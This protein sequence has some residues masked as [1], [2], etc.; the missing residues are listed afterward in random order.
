MSRSGALHRDDHAGRAVE[1]RRDVD[2]VFGPVLQADEDLR[3]LVDGEGGV[4]RPREAEHPFRVGDDVEFV[5]RLSV[6]HL[7]E[8]AV[9]GIEWP[10]KLPDI[11]PSNAA[12][13]MVHDQAEL[14]ALTG[15]TV[16]TGTGDNM[17]A[18]LGLAVK[19]GDTVISLGTSGTIYG[20]TETGVRDATGAINGYADAT[21]AFLP[22]GDSEMKAIGGADKFVKTALDTGG[23]AGKTV[24]SVPLYG[25][26]YGLYY[27]KKMFSDAG[28][29]PPTNWEELVTDAKKL[30]N[31]T[32]YGFSLAAGS[33]TEN[34]HFAFINS[35]QNGGEWFDSKGNP[36]FTSS[37]NV[38]GIK[39][40]LDLM[41]TDKVVNTSNA[42]Y[43]NGVQAVNDFATG[44]VAMILSQNN[45]DSSINANGMKSDAYGVVPFPSP[46]GGKPVA[47]HVATV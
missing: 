39:R 42:Q 22:F 5:V 37:A 6:R 46:E 11:L 29:Q 7:A 30:T 31:G 35:A 23:A 27:N 45:A 41:Q 13:G 10:A 47:S 34:A 40:Y 12:A 17:T 28:V 2:D 33:Y 1:D 4:V 24:T 3:R 43:D 20:L 26:A 15:A 32:Q 36:T 14:G 21:G 18:A 8:L 25:L 44:K 19:P 9:P 38:D 16:G